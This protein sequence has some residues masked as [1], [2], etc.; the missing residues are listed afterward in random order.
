MGK[1]TSLYRYTPKNSYYLKYYNPINIPMDS[2]DYILTIKPE[3]NNKPGKLAYDLYNSERLYWI[4][5]YFNSDKINDP[6]FD[7]KEGMTIRVPT[8]ERLFKYI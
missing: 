5:K 4:F 3:Y 7:L 8:S 1:T 6:I 2:T